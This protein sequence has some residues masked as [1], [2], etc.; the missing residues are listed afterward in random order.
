ML[1]NSGKISTAKISSFGFIM[2]YAVDVIGLNVISTE[3]TMIK[4]NKGEEKDE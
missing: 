1:Y 4:S 3:L 2:S